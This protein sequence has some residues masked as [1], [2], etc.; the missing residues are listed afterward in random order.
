[1][2]MMPKTL[3][4]DPTTSAKALFQLALGAMA[5]AGLDNVE[6]PMTLGGIDMVIR[7]TVVEL[8]GYRDDD[9]I[10][11]D[12]VTLP[13][14]AHFVAMPVATLQQELEAAQTQQNAGTLYPDE[15]FE[16]GV[17]A[18]LRWMLGAQGAPV[19]EELE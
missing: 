10:K 8:A 19:S 14:Q 3:Q 6:L 15:G 9:A 12:A 1:M 11:G 17:V 7:M 2:D 13:A 16:D 4:L 5:D 18:T